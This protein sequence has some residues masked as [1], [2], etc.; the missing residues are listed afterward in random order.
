RSYTGSRAPACPCRP[1]V[2]QPP[3]R[4]PAGARSGGGWGRAPV[5]SDHRRATPASRA[6]RHAGASG[7]C[8]GT[9]PPRLRGT[10]Q[11][12][13]TRRSTAHGAFGALAYGI[14]TSEVE[15]VLATQT[16]I[17][18]KSNNMRVA[19]DGRLPSDVSAK[20]IILAVIGEIGA[21]GG[22][23]HAMEFCGD[24]IRAL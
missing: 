16:L 14:G 19:V 17:Q 22:I 15:H 6:H 5:S 4:S 11:T 3:S 21:A 20:D 12:P 8:R 24:A 9:R 10:R 23:G 1:G 2:P 18:R 7:P 13:A